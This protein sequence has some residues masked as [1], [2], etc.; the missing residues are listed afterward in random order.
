MMRWLV[1]LGLSWLSGCTL[2]T[3]PPAPEARPAQFETASFAMNGRISVNNYG[4]RHSAG[5]HWTHHG[6]SDEILL[7]TPLGQT[8]ARVYRDERN[9]TLDDG[10]KHYQADDAEALMEK[11]LGWYLPLRGLHQW[12]LGLP[13]T[14]SPVQIK[15]DSKGRISELFQDGWEV[16]YLR[17]ADSR[18]DSLPTRLQLSLEHLK[19]QLLIDEWQWNPH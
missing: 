3:T 7:L 13:D 18:A 6:Q 17:Y 1:I 19:V 8:A 15:R 9:A 2:L 12:V 10:D 16:R 4:V 11:V 14:G 5:L